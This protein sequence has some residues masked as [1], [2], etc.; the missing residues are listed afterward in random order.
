M[1]TENYPKWAIRMT[2]WMYT[3]NTKDVETCLRRQSCAPLGGRNIWATLNSIDSSSS[4]HLIIA[5]ASYDSNAFFH[6]LAL[7]SDSDI[8]GAVALMGAI[9]SLATVNRDL[10]KKQPV[11]V[12]FTGESYGFIGSKAFVKD[13]SNF[14][15]EEPSGSS[16]VDPYRLDTSFTKLHLDMVDSYLELNQVGHFDASE[17]VKLY[18]HKEASAGDTTEIQNA[19]R[20]ATNGVCFIF[21]I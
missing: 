16:C 4:E 3:R 1:Q 15:C 13:I 21:H 18:S 20:T 8:S 10:W 5:A 19:L 12:L 14:T 7:G 9:Q 6:D 2:S 17:D 11:F